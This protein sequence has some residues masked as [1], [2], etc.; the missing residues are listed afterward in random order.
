MNEP[1]P[2]QHNIGGKSV[3]G[4][5]ICKT[6]QKKATNKI[7][8]PKKNCFPSCFY[9]KLYIFL[10]NRILHKLVNFVGENNQTKNKLNRIDDR[11]KHWKNTS[12]TTLFI[13]GVNC[14][15]SCTW[16][17][18]KSEKFSPEIKY[19][20]VKP[21]YLNGSRGVGFKPGI[22][23]VFFRYGTC[24]FLDATGRNSLS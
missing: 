24:N 4:R 10:I 23:Q 18:S 7:N 3:H 13:R 17:S 21:T 6:C 1:R 9:V 5:N 11:K 2:Q 14:D 15:Q 22:R 20:S 12:A 8:S 16:F 19:P